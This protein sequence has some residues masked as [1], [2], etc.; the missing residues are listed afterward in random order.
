MINDIYMAIS[1]VINVNNFAIN[2]CMFSVIAISFISNIILLYSYVY[3]LSAF[4]FY[5]FVE[6]LYIPLNTRSVITKRINIFPPLPPW[7]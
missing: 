6:K 2:V 3:V 5:L 1:S 7:K 4:N